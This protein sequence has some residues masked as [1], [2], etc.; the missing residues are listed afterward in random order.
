MVL[1]KI[2]S[3][4]IER[5][6]ITENPAAKVHRYKLDNART[7]EL[8]YEQ[9]KQLIAA[10]RAD[11]KD[12]EHEFL[13]ALHTGVRRSNLYGIHGKDRKS[14]PPLDW[15]DVDLDFKVLKLPRSKGGKYSLPLNEIAVKALDELRKRSD[16][17]G[18]VIRKASGLE[19]HSCRRWFETCVEKAGI[20]DFH[21]HDLRHTFATRLRRNRVPIEDIAALMGHDL[22]KYRMTAR[23]AHP[24]LDVLREAVATLVPPAETA[25]GT[26]T[27]TGTAVAPFRRAESA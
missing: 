11:Y 6:E 26:G 19:I 2:F 24:D 3:L 16:G 18:P 17:T 13:L 9:E 20:E 1:S 15:N 12:K 21:Y 14:M 25:T 27:N 22:K 5:K 23:Y 10:I 7:V 4:A 8:S